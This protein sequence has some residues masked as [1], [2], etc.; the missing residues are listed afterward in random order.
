MVNSAK[1][2]D[3]LNK[4]YRMFGSMFGY[5]LIDPIDSR[6]FN[7]HNKAGDSLVKKGLVI[8]IKG[9]RE[10]KLRDGK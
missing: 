9:S 2:L 5:Y 6:C 3:L 8:K 10:Y 1:T 7:V 4:G